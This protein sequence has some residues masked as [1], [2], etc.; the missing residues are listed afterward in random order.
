[1]HFFWAHL[2]KQLQKS[3]QAELKLKQVELENRIVKTQVARLE[4]IVQASVGH[5]KAGT[6][7]AI[8]GVEWNSSI[9]FYVLSETQ[10]WHDTSSCSFD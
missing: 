5:S 7:N 1:M 6:S 9:L 3:Q 2:E 8:F 4:Q 10:F